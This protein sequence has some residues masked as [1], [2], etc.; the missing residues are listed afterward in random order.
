[1]SSDGGDELRLI[2]GTFLCV[3]CFLC[4]RRGQN[5]SCTS[6]SSSE[7]ASTSYGEGC[8]SPAL[9]AEDHEK[10]SDW[11]DE[12]RNRRKGEDLFVRLDSLSSRD[13]M[14]RERE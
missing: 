7:S 13:E 10:L 4:L 8:P 1:M 6:C 3:A 5:V 2:E 11:K 9:S 12:V 14:E